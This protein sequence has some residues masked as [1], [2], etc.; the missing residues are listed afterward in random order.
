MR[1]GN[2]SPYI[3]KKEKTKEKEKKRKPSYGL[4]KKIKDFFYPPE[5]GPT[6]V[7][8]YGAPI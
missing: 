1:S 2:S 5:G 4:K 6:D 8:P 7:V 3:K